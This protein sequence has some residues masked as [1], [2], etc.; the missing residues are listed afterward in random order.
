M[1]FSLELLR[2]FTSRE[3]RNARASLFDRSVILTSHFEYWYI[4]KRTPA[5]R[6][7]Y[8]GR[9]KQ[10]TMAMFAS[11]DVL[12]HNVCLEGKDRLNSMTG[13]H[14]FEIQLAELT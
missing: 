1:T 3:S 7:M 5:L 14:T 11:T 2:A 10:K 9:R 4:L 12:C 6:D 13:R 8:D